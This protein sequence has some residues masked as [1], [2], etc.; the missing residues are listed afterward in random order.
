[1]GLSIV[2]GTKQLTEAEYF[3]DFIDLLGDA[4]LIFL[5]LIQVIQLLKQVLHVTLPSSSSSSPSLSPC[6]RR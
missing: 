1:M 2:M 3:V 5:Q 4:V 6:P